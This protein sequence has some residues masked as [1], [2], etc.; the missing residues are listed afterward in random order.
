[1]AKIE[2]GKVTLTLERVQ[3]QGLVSQTMESLRPLATQKGLSLAADLPATPIVIDSDWRALTQ[4]IIDLTNSAIKFTGHGTERLSLAQHLDRRQLVTEF[5]VTT[6]GIG[7]RPEDQP[8]LLQRFR[9]SI[10]LLSRV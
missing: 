7:I 8:K 9:S 5:S 10:R 3:C 6:S 2:T 4:I 1:M